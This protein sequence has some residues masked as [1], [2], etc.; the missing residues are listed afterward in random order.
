[1]PKKKV[2]R[3]EDRV[4]KLVVHRSQVLGILGDTEYA[5]GYLDGVTKA[6]QIVSGLDSIERAILTA[7][8]ETREQ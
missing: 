3:I 2:D 4:I 6:I 5:I 1:M 8:I 7:K